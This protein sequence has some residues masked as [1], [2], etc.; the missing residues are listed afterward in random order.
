MNCLEI[1][2]QMMLTVILGIPSPKDPPKSL[3]RS[4]NPS[5]PIQHKP[6]QITQMTHG[7]GQLPAGISSQELYEVFSLLFDIATLG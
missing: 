1:V 5:L 4:L 3:L 7:H 6:L 2:H